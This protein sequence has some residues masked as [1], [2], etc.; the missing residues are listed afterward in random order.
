MFPCCPLQPAPTHLEASVNLLVVA[1]IPSSC[2]G[3]FQKFARSRCSSCPLNPAAPQFIPAQRVPVAGAAGGGAGQVRGRDGPSRA[4]GGRRGVSGGAGAVG[5]PWGSPR[6]PPGCQGP[7]PGRCPRSRLPRL[8][9]GTAPRPG[10]TARGHPGPRLLNTWG[11][12]G[13]REREKIENK[14]E[15]EVKVMS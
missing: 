11:W 14:S 12:A 1:S 10:P 8:G 3:L 6:L 2:F 4:P 7:R 5:R 9:A 15:Q 13:V